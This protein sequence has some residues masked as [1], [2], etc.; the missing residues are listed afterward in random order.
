M[1]KNKTRKSVRPALNL[2]RGSMHPAFLFL[3]LLSAFP[4]AAQQL[5]IGADNMNVCYIGVDNPI[6]AAA[7]GCDARHLA[8][9]TANGSIVRDTG[10]GFAYRP[11]SAGVAEIAAYCVRGR[12]SVLMGKV[13]F[14]VKTLPRPRAY[15]LPA[16]SDEPGRGPF[17]AREIVAI[18]EGFDFNV[19]F[20]ITGFDFSRKSQNGSVSEKLH[21]DTGTFTLHIKA[22]ISSSYP[23]D[24]LYFENIRCKGPDGM[25]HELGNLYVTM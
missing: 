9:K 14:R 13:P 8:L 19:Q 15:F 7:F 16:R 24:K 2:F 23:G 3:L 4:A 17:R 11:A 5:V 25:E 10:D 1:E 12:D 21:S 6:S 20:T 18:L 22:L